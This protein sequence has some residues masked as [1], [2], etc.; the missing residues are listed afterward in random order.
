MSISPAQLVQQAASAGSAS[1]KQGSSP[2]P[3]LSVAL[4]SS[5]P[6]EPPSAPPSAI[7]PVQ[8][9]TDFQIDSHHQVFYEVVDDSTGDVLLEIPSEA[10]RKIGESLNL[11]LAGDPN[12]PIVDVKS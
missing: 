7:P 1:E 6:A 8:F 4:G 9:S 5:E 12:V 11:P 2:S 3:I 10:L